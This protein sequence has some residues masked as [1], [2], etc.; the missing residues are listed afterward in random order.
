MI[1]PDS[2]SKP[3]NAVNRQRRPQAPL[4]K[5]AWLRVAREWI[6]LAQAADER[7]K[8]DKGRAFNGPSVAIASHAISL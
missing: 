6:K 1:Q 8:R 3:R 5:E 4:D 2:A 7:G